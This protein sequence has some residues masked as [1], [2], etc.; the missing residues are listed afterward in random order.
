LKQSSAHLSSKAR[1]CMPIDR[2]EPMCDGGVD[3]HIGVLVNSN[4]DASASSSRTTA[5]RNRTREDR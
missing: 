5:L 3:V 1:A 2:S 4:P